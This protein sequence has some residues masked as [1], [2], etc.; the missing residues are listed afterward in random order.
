MGKKRVFVACKLKKKSL[1][2]SKKSK[3]YWAEV[4][5]ELTGAVVVVEKEGAKLKVKG[6]R[7]P[8]SFLVTNTASLVMALA[9]L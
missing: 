1:K 3:C 5:V 4:Q 7:A 6:T 2:K 8:K 9:E